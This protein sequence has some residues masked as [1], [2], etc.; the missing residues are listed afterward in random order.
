MTKTL[1]ID[2][3]R[4]I[5]KSIVIYIS[6]IIFTMLCVA[7]YIGLEWGTESITKSLDDAM[8]TGNLYDIRI[9]YD[10][11]LSENDIKIISEINEIDE[12]TVTRLGYGIFINNGNQ[13]IQARIQE[14]SDSMNLP[15]N[16]EGNLPKNSNE[17]AVSKNW[18]N[19]NNIKIGDT[20]SFLSDNSMFSTL[21]ENELIVT[22]FMDT[23]EYNQLNTPGYGVSELNNLPVG[24]ILYVSKE[25][26]N[27]LIYQDGNQI[28]IKCNR[29]RAFSSFEDE[30]ITEKEKIK[31]TISE[32]LT[33]NG[34]SG[35]MM[36][37]R[38]CLLQHG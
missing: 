8:V 26:F 14:I 9:L 5:K 2:S 18:A 33:K 4:I 27:P 29:L 15:M 12:I 28:L 19:D 17:A 36:T 3:V 31:S 24:C 7:L 34:L 21:T 6:I 30:Y 22:A 38:T 20:I 23:V 32:V 1:L 13:R 25:A 37:D 16:P 10:H 11:G 35:F